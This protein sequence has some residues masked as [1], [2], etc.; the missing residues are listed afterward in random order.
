MII[1]QYKRYTT[2]DNCGE[3]S[4]SLFKFAPIYMYPCI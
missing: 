2:G 1:T 3:K 4:E